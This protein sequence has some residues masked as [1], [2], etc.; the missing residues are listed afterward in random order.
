M[1]LV[2]TLIVWWF[3]IA[4]LVGSWFF[5]SAFTGPLVST[6]GHI[7]FILAVMAGLGY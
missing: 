2:V 6:I 7:A 5:V 1:E 4:F 3:G